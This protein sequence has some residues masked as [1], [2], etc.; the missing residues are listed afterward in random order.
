[1]IKVNVKNLKYKLSIEL[2]KIIKNVGEF[3]NE[4]ILDGLREPTPTKQDLIELNQL[5]IRKLNTLVVSAD[6]QLYT[7]T[8]T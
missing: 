4:T 2:I 5:V 6:Y 7:K 1:M 8:E 3:I